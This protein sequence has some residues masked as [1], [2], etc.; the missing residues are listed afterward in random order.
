MADP[1]TNYSHSDVGKAAVRVLEA[2]GVRVRIPDDVGDSGRS[3][4]SKSMLDHAREKA[5]GNVD[6]LAPRVRDGW[7]LAAALAA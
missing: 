7:D 2:A 3:A 6:A 1:Y 4:F 5:R